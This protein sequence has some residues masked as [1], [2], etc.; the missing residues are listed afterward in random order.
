MTVK[1]KIKQGDF[2]TDY[3]LTVEGVDWSTASG[4]TVTL[5]V[6]KGDVTLIDGGTCS[7]VQNGS[8]TDVGYT[9]AAGNFDTVGIWNAEIKAIQST[10]FK[11]SSITFEWEV[12]ESSPDTS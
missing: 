3:T 2:G 1:V 4:Y 9:V 10:T 8:D 12:L 7:A 6:W 5:H 11:E